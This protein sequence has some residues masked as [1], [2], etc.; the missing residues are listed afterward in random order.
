[1]RSLWGVGA[2]GGSQG[3]GKSISLISE[4]CVRV[5][6]P[7]DVREEEVAGSATH[8]EPR[9]PRILAFKSLKMLS[10]DAHHSPKILRD[11]GHPPPTL[12]NPC[13]GTRHSRPR[14]MAR[15]TA[16]PLRSPPPSGRCS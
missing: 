1:M 11:V 7:K 4:L 15:Q 8:A 6:V 12:L 9:L 5:L 3:K 2:C 10:L 14:S 13:T 16:R